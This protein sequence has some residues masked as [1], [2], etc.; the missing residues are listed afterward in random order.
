MGRQVIVEQARWFRV[1]RLA[2]CGPVPRLA[3]EC[4]GAKSRGDEADEGCDDDDQRERNGEE[5]NAGE[6][7]GGEPDQ[8]RVTKCP[9]SHAHHRFDHDRQHGGLQTEEHGRHDRHLAPR[10][11]DHA[12]RH[13]RDHPRQDEQHPGHHAP[14]RAMHEPTDVGCELL[15]F[16]TWQQHAV[17]E[18]M[19]KSLLGNPA[20]FLHE[21][22]VHHGNLACRATKTQRRNKS[23]CPE[24]L[25][26]RHP[27]R[28]SVGRSLSDAE[29]GLVIH[30]A[31]HALG[32][33]VGQLCVSSCASRAQR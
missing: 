14:G 12:E 33:L 26:P 19:Q 6:G 20:L 28:G 11:V 1:S 16:G 23:P 13:D 7:K 27:M 4:V 29:R 24:R 18:R 9:A 2:S 17:V 32:L 31:L 8:C 22:A 5:E 21:D 15:R 3:S 10:C 25:V 30:V